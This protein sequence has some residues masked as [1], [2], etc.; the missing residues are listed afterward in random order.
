MTERD[1]NVAREKS[2]HVWQPERSSLTREDF[3]K[4]VEELIG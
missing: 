4:I 1:D 3:R 2:S